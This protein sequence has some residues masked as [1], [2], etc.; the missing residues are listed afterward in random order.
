M[1]KTILRT[2]FAVALAAAAGSSLRASAEEMKPM[3]PP[4][5]AQTA[6]RE[7]MKACG[8]EW[9]EMKTSGKTEAGMTWRKYW[10]TCN[11]RLKGMKDMKA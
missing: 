1:N 9:K 4:S 7:R 2:T 3:K 8:G 5:A 6:M 10:S 11:A